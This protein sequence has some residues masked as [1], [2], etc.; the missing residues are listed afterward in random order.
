[1][2][3]HPLRSR[4]NIFA[5]LTLSFLN[6]SCHTKLLLLR[7]IYYLSVLFLTCRQQINHNKNQ[8]L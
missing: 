8:Y 6:P 4:Q 7:H 5:N 3:I 1:M 2:E